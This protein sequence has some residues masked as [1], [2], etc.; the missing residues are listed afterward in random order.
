[1]SRDG[2]KPGEA[3]VLARLSLLV[4][5]AAML[6]FARGFPLRVD[7]E[8]G[9]ERRTR[10]RYLAR[11]ELAD[12]ERAPRIVV[13]SARTGEYVCRSLIGDWFAIDPASPWNHLADVDVDER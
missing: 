10:R 8:W 5:R 11:V 2:V 7:F 6:M 1:M 13:H 3:V 9:D 4:D 12:G